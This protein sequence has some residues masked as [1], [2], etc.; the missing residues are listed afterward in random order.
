VD[1]ESQPYLDRGDLV[2]YRG[3]QNAKLFTLHRL[4]TTHTRLRLME[5]HA[6]SLADSVISFNAVHC[7]VSR[8]ETGSFK[9]RTFLLEELC[10]ASGLEHEARPVQEGNHVCCSCWRS[11][12][13]SAVSTSTCPDRMADLG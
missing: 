9:D 10:S 11:R 4:A 1:L 13:I 5:V 12:V 2:L 8:T 6:R 7:N 3:V